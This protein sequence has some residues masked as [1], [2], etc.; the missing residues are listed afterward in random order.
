MANKK[1]QLK[2]LTLFL[3]DY[4]FLVMQENGVDRRYITCRYCNSRLRLR[5][6]RRVVGNETEV[7]RASGQPS[8]E[9]TAV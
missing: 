3:K 9:I 2:K 1:G 7:V 8:Y 5:R 6:K 4:N